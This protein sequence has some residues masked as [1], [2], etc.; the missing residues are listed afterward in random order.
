MNHNSGMIIHHHPFSLNESNLSKLQNLSTK[1][2]QNSS[3]VIH[4]Q[5]FVKAP[6][7]VLIKDEETKKLI[8]EQLISAG[9][10]IVP[11][12]QAR[13]LVSESQIIQH[14]DI[15]FVSTKL[16]R[17][18]THQSSHLSHETLSPSQKNILLSQIPWTIQNTPKQDTKSR[19]FSP[20]FTPPE[21]KPS[22]IN[23]MVLVISDMKK[24]LSPIIRQLK[25]DP[26]LYIGEVPKNYPVTPFDPIHPQSIELMR[27]Y[28]ET[29]KSKPHIEIGMPK[30]GFCAI[31]EQNY[32]NAE[33]HHRSFVHT[34]QAEKLDWTEFDQLA[35]ILNAQFIN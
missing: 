19:T 27:K 23:D 14:P 18:R 32:H 10:Q 34:T 5:F 6:V 25:S 35:L 2:E 26:T 29:I 16:K 31:C 17:S 24:N 4:R 15:S 30:T 22:K 8:E 28:K 21:I 13:Y 1:Y 33:M 11:S 20:V 12:S 7:A 3:Q 9:A